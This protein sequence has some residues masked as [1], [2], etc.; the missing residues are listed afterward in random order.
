MDQT[1][2]EQK[3]LDSTFERLFLAHPRD[4]GTTYFGHMKGAFA[5]SGRMFVASIAC[6]F[7]AFVPGLFK[8]AASGTVTELDREFDARRSDMASY[9][10]L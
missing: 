3:P 5:I 7:H 10:G 4:L 6:F 2:L 1:R 9:L 8:D